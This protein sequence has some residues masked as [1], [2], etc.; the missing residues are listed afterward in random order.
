MELTDEQKKRV[1][2][3]I[4]EGLKLGD[5]QGRLDTEFSIRM[6][7]M[8]V[9]LLVDDL[10]LT[11]KEATPEPAAAPAA[12]APEAEGAADLA[13]APLPA[14]SGKVQLSVD[15]ITRAGALASGSVTFSDAQSAAWTLDQYG[16]L[17]LSA[18]QQG[19]RPSP[20]DFAEFQVLLEKELARLGI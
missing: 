19:Y 8:D 7:Y 6:T 15:Q 4:A 14:T 20:E 18:T 13:E 5:I 10:K 3:W 9:R 11:P 12:D 17:G 2:D 1:A 16:R